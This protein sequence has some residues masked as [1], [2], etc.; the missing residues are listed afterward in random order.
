MAGEINASIVSAKSILFI[1][2]KTFFEA[3]DFFT[4]SFIH[5]IRKSRSRR[6]WRD[7]LSRQRGFVG[8]GRAATTT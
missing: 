8:F 2:V 6:A 7:L 1:I 3:L 5:L 4:S